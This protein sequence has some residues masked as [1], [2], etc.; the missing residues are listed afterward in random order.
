[1]D[2]EATDIE[3]V[4]VVTPRRHRDERGWFAE[5]WNPRRMDGP[6]SE[7]AFVQ[8]NQSVSLRR[9]TV[10]GLHFQAPPFAQA[11]LVHCARGAILDIAV[12]IRAGSP[13][14]GKHVAIELS[15]ENG[16][17]LFVP[18]GFLHGFM[19]LQENTLVAYKV[20]DFYHGPAEG[21]VLWNSPSLGIEWPATAEA[22][23]L[24]DKD[25]E[26]RDFA[27]FRTPFV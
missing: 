1:M 10:R 25:A 20:T 11:K 13:T 22:V 6:L 17:Q 5:S 15:E 12:D 26:G 4:L 3:S 21:T 7:I 16:R 8:D 27:S 19:T 23:T 24:S 2:I 9:H 14:F 18:E